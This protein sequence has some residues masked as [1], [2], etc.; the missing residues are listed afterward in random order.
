MFKIKNCNFSIRFLLPFVIGS[1]AGGVLYLAIGWWGF[2]LIFPYIGGCISAGIIVSSCLRGKDKDLGRKIAIL[3]ISPVFL[4]FLGLIQRENLQ[5][6]ET[7]FYAAFFLSSG[8]FTRVLIHYAVAKIGGPLIWGRGFCGWA[9]WTAAVLDWLPIAENR[10]IPRKMIFL[11]W[12]V[13]LISLLVP[14]LFL[15]AGY[16]YQRLHIDTA[17]GKQG[18]LLWFIAGN[19]FYYAS[20][21]FLAFIYRKKRAFCK[22]MCPVSLVMKPGTCFTL[23]RKKPTGNNCINCGK[24]NEICPMDVDVM[25]MIGSGMPVR[26]TECIICG[27]CVN[28]CPVSAVD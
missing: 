10:P 23:I 4:I 6:E 27:Q 19:L 13:L 12:P 24:C 3:S 1:I 17:Q 20:A 5:I 9:C 11:R 28:V 26:S 2:L 14:V 22:I 7:V 8:V 16:D 15:I 21:V 25:S 18:Q